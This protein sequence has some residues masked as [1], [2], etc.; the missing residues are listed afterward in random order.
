MPQ[1][2][3]N[4]MVEAKQCDYRPRQT[5]RVPGGRGSQISGQSAHEG[6]TVVSPKH[7][8]PLPPGIIPGTYF[9]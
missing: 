5:L 3:V 2:I 7:R 6:V 8:S 1:A 4:T 9:C